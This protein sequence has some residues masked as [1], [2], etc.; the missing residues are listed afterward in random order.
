MVTELKR[1]RQRYDTAANFTSGNPTLLAGEIGIESDT[2][3]MKIGDGS[4]A[5]TSLAYASVGVTARDTSLGRL[6]IGGYEV[7]DTG[8]RDV[9]SSW[10]GGN[11]TWNNLYVRRIGSIVKIQGNFEFTAASSS[12][13]LVSLAAGF[14]SNNPVVD[15]L[16]AA[17][18]YVPLL[19]PADA[20]DTTNQGVPALGF[21]AS[22]YLSSS[23]KAI[24]GQ[25]NPVYIVAE[26]TTD[27]AWPTSLPGTAA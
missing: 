14:Q 9:A 25:G 12:A 1:M 19:H 26:F 7:G 20:Y 15:G 2:K 8:W 16:N 10:G 5:W 3:N 13:A 24:Y 21:A 18:R 22:I 6:A 27:D 4:T 23:H 17:M 11:F